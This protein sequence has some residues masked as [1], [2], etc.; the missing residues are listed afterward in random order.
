MFVVYDGENE[1][2]VTTKKREDLCLEEH[3]GEGVRNINDYTR[4]EVWGEPAVIISN[5]INV[6]IV[7]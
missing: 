5:Q 7:W 3:F 4:H 2:I 6:D 1:V